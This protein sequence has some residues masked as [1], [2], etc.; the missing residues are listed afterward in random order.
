[1]YMC[2]LLLSMTQFVKVLC[3][4]LPTVILFICLIIQL[5]KEIGLS[6]GKPCDFYD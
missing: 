5:H 2:L 1:M 4:S 6:E 3:V